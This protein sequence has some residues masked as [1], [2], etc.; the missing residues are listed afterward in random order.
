MAA[1]DGRL[2]AI[3]DALGPDFFGHA[4]GGPPGMLL[5]H[6]CWVGNPRIVG[7]LLERGA[8]PVA[9]SGAES[10]T[11]AAWAALGSQGHAMPGRDYVG[12][13]KLLLAAGA[14][15]EPRFVEVAEGPLRTGS[16]RLLE[17]PPVATLNEVLESR[18]TFH[19]DLIP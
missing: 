18:S 7:R 6:A 10:D 16:P 3:V 15:L 17:P 8:D 12:V 2:Y 9:R 14:Q 1:L 5:H 19:E 11:P 13:M 4:G